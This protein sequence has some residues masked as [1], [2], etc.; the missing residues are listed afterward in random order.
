MKKRILAGVLASAAALTAVSFSGCND[1]GAGNENTT[2]DGTKLRIACWNYEVAEWFNAY[3]ADKIPSG[4]TVEWVQFP[5]EGSN[6]QDNLDRLLKANADASA[7]QK[8]DIF[9]A[10]ADYIRKYVESDYS[11]SLDISTANA[12]QYTVDAAKDSNGNLKAISCQATPSGVIIR[13]SIAKEVLGT[14]DPEE[15]QAKLDSWEKFEAVA[16]DAKAKG[17]LMTGSVLE[18]YRAFANNSTTGYI[19]NGK[20]ALTDAFNQWYTQAEKFVKEGYTQTCKLWDDE[21]TNE[22]YKDGKVMCYFGPM[23][24]YAFSMGKAFTATD[25]PN[26]SIGDWAFIEGPANFYWGG[27]WMLGANG[28]DN[29][30]LVMQ[31]LNDWQNDETLLANLSKGDVDE[32]NTTDGTPLGNKKHNP[33]FVNN[34]N[35]VAKNAADASMAFEGFGGQNDWAVQSEIAN[36]I[37]WDNNVHYAIDQ[38][39]NETLPE[40]FIDV[41]KG[42]ATKDEALANFYKTLNEKDPSITHD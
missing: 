39:L 21:K 33:C 1:N 9:L 22:M 4:V 18:T 19:Q 17:Y 11:L 36:G 13:R 3:Y 25:N 35:V 37:K 40:A 30:D 6:Y 31:F 10:E 34:K 8:I 41:F 5:N 2:N 38:T 15:M 16:A 14:D 24:Y 26:N 7:D 42:T 12:Y 29:Y 28:T 27:T 20:F 32:L 23:W